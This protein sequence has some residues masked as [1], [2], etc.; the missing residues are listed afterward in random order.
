MCVSFDQ[1]F[2]LFSRPGQEAQ[3]IYKAVYPMDT[4]Q[5]KT[6]L[7][8]YGFSLLEGNKI[9]TALVVQFH[10]IFVYIYFKLI[11]YFIFRY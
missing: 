1:V 2:F 6:K 10:G 8:G 11:Y 7:I 3:K 5:V 4:T 9:G